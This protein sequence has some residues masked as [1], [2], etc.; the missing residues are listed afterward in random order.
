M[1]APFCSGILGGQSAELGTGKGRVPAGD[2]AKVP[3]PRR[4]LAL[5][6]VQAGGGAGSGLGTAPPTEASLAPSMGGAVV[7]R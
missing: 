2:T 7:P 1:S 6:T 3:L 5:C 4:R